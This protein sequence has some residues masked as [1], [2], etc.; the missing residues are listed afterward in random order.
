M[1]SPGSS[2]TQIIVGSRRS[3]WQIAQRGPS[4]RLKQISQRLIFSFTSRIASASAAASSAEVRR[5]WKA[6]RCAVRLPMPGSLPS[7]VT[8]RWR[9]GASKA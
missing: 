5:M 8:S 9:G 7:S 3:S 4:A 1:T 2:T 6:S